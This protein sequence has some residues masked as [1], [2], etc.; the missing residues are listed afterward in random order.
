MAAITF[1]SLES[2]DQDFFKEK[3]NS[4]N[5]LYFIEAGEPIPQDTEVLSLFVNVSVDA[6]LLDTLPN[7]QFIACRSTGFDNV[8]IEATNA[9]GIKVAN[10][11]AYGCTSVGEF[12]LLLILALTRKLKETLNETNA[13][14]ANRENERG[15]DFAGKTLGIIGTGTIGR[16]VA[17]MAKGFEAKVIA[18]DVFP[19]PEL[20]AEI[21]FEYVSL[22]ELLANSDIVSIHAPSNKDTRHMI[23]SDRLA[24]MQSH[25]IFINTARG[26][27]VDTHALVEA[28][29]NKR[30]R[31]AA[32]DV[33]EQER[34][35]NLP[36][37]PL[38]DQF[39]ILRSLPNVILTN[40]NAFNSE[41][42][43]AVINGTTRDN[44]LNFLSGKPENIVA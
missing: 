9:K 25:A 27:L 41:E 5:T 30:L 28:L 14:N 31:A 26:D 36:S 42:S 11:P 29:Q 34:T 13:V 8:D 18:F 32:L 35:M 6:K 15:T 7:L 24:L 43:V 2:G 20:A 16:C 3:L 22:D 37:S 38:V 40:H 10:V 17:R 4:N 21:G 1:I 23:N 39:K 44:I 12:T 33:V 19:R